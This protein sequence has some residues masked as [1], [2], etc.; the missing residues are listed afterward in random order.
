MPFV[1]SAQVGGQNSFQV[2][3]YATSARTESLGG[4]AIT[5]RDDDATLG[6]ENRALSSRTIH[7]MVI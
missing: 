3:N 1:V 6:Q 2:W 5:M 7:A 4:Y